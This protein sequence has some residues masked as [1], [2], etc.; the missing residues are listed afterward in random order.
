MRFSFSSAP[1][2]AACLVLSFLV[3]PARADSQRLTG[4]DT[5]Q[6]A[7]ALVQHCFTALNNGRDNGDGCAGIVAATISACLHRRPAAPR[8]DSAD[9]NMLS[10]ITANVSRLEQRL[11]CIGEASRACLRSPYAGTVLRATRCLDLETRIWEIHMNREYVF[12]YTNLAPDQRLA[13]RRVQQYWRK[14]RNAKCELLQRV[15]TTPDGWIETADCRLELAGRRVLE[16]QD[17]RRYL[18]R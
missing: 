2:I 14:Y 8:P 3:L 15:I 13:L 18:F 9:T 7:A 10:A 1:Q 16:L 17:L 5:S 6:Q 11:S 12:V 4:A